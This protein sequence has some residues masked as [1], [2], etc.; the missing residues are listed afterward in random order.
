MLLFYVFL[1]LAS[2]A[3]CCFLLP[4]KQNKTKHL[5]KQNK[6]KQKTNKKQKVTM[7]L[8]YDGSRRCFPALGQG[9]S[10]WDL[11]IRRGAPDF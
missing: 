3:K 11:K 8:G 1:G 4:L 2:L 9:L 6:T 10:I 7:E 5:N